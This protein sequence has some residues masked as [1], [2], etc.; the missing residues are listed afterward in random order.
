MNISQLLTKGYDWL[1]KQ[2]IE[3]YL[4]DTQLLLCK[5]LNVEKL[6]IMMNRQLEVSKENEEEFLKLLALRKDKMPMK[7]I[8]GVCEFM[9]L[10]FSVK[11]GVLIPR[12]DTEILVEECI[13]LINKNNL[14]EACDVC[15]GSGAIG[16]LL[17]T[18]QI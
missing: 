17:H 15:C 2:N 8:L 5:V 16:F 10:E 11:E 9:G 3:S 12:P 7:Y 4:I 18:T 14:K 13:S 6:F 1:K